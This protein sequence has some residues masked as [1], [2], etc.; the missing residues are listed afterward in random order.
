MTDWASVGLTILSLALAFIAI[1]SAGKYRQVKRLLK[2]TARAL[3]TVSDA[4]EDDKITRKEAKK[5]VEDWS[6]V[7]EDAKELIGKKKKEIIWKA[8]QD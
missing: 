7:I 5:I 1:H 6:H 2:S 3:T 8:K 4:I